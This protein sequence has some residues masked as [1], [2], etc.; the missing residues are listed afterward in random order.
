[1]TENQVDDTSYMDLLFQNKLPEAYEACMNALKTCKPSRE[2]IHK[3]ILCHILNSM[4]RHNES[5]VILERLVLESP[6][7]H[8]LL[9]N[10]AAVKRML[11]QY[12]NALEMF[13]KERSMIENSNDALSIATNAYELGKTNHMLENHEE[14][15]KYATL[16]FLVSQKCEDPIMHGCV[17]RLLGDLYSSYCKEIGL[18]FYDQAKSYFSKGMDPRAVTD[19]DQRVESVINGKDPKFIS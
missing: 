13:E 2:R 15:L 7:D 11:G 18:T 19:I 12:Q 8:R 1:M 4:G 14:A 16:S 10:W 9:H 5:D 17:Y 3:G 6:D